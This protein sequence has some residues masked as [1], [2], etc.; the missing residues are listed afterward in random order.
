VEEADLE[1][2]KEIEKLIAGETISKPVHEEI[3]YGDI[4]ES[5]DNLWNF[6][7]FTGYLK[8]QCEW[9]EDGTI[10]MELAIP[11]MEIRCIYRN[12]ILA[13]FDRKIG[14]TDMS[15]FFQAID[16]EDCEGMSDFI[17]N[18]LLDTISFFDYAENYYHG[19]LV[20]LLKASKKYLV[21]SNRE[22]G[23]GRTDILL[24]TPSVRG[25]AVIIELKTAAR[26]QEMEKKCQEALQQI[27]EKN[28]EA[29]LRK[30]GYS[31]I[32]K[33]GICF[34]KKECLVRK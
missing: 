24:R 34:Y 7:Y 12:T 1:T 13:W 6:L 18:Q 32:A 10:Y 14:Q 25:N 23:M 15:S 29:E 28:Y 31:H 33:F 5:K 8:K 19:F 20:G 21:S 4:H 16:H 27:E 11:N 26:F 22:S 30:E 9:L 2:R 17:S 3:T